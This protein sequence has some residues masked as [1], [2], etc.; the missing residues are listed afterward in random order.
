MKKYLLVALIAL[1][2]VTL[3]VT[4][5]GW[6]WADS[7][8][9][10]TKRQFEDGGSGG[11]GTGLMACNAGNSQQIVYMTTNRLVPNWG[12]GYYHYW[13]CDYGDTFTQDLWDY[14]HGAYFADPC[15]LWWAGNS[16]G[17]KAG[18]SPYDTK[19]Y[20]RWNWEYFSS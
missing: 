6:T 19:Y 9:A 5:G 14:N 7:A 4:G 3:A 17:C 15:W 18:D 20:D 8:H 13:I 10:A 2:V 12:S 11:S 1:A 16:T